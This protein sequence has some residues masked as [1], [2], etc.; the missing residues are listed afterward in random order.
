MTAGRRRSGG[1]EGVG[2]RPTLSQGEVSK[3]QLPVTMEE[4]RRPPLEAQMGVLVLSVLSWSV[5][6]WEEGRCVRLCELYCRGVESARVEPD[7]WRAS[8]DIRRRSVTAPPDQGEREKG[9][10]TRD[11]PSAPPASGRHTSTGGH[12]D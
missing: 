9:D 12:A 2:V 7:G 6:V 3:G 10:W 1:G 5:G 8:I 11:C 4:S